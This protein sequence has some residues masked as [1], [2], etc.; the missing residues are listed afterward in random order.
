MYFRSD[1]VSG[2]SHIKPT[3]D[4]VLTEEVAYLVFPADPVIGV[5]D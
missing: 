2:V 1:I 4:L 5:I 3:H